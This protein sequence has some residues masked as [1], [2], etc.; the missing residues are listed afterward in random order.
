MLPQELGDVDVDVDGAA[1]LL[2]KVKFS[3][4]LLWM[5]DLCGRVKHTD[6]KCIY[7]KKLYMYFIIQARNNIITECYVNGRIL[8]KKHTKWSCQVV[9]G[10]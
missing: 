3:S 5:L 1:L 8:E 9:V 6:G 10:S 2:A 4:A 7:T